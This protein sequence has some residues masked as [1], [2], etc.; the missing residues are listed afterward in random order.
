MTEEMYDRDELRSAQGALGTLLGALPGPFVLLGGWAV[1]H[2][3]QGSYRRD[4]GISYLG[5]RDLDVGYHVDPSWSD[6]ELR[7]SA[8]SRA[9]E[10]ARGI[11]YSPMGSFR[12][13][14]FVQKM[15]GW[16]LTEE[17]SK[18]V[19]IH[20]LFYL[21]LDFMVD[22]I[23]PRQANVLGPKAMDE[24]LLARV[25]EEG[26]GVWIQVGEAEVLAPPPHL[27]LAMKLK[28]IPSRQKE[29]KVIKDACDIYALLWH[30]PHGIDGVLRPVRAD[31]PEEC[32]FGLDA[33]TH[34]VARRASGHLGVDIESYLGVVRQLRP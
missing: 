24:P 21:Y 22:H 2:T 9:I 20:D 28:S 4:H 11:G 8:L 29:D 32:L 10:V 7:A 6:D 33:I 17:E 15:T 5:S 30:S 31:Y 27:L 1:Y 12:F 13:C 16:T 23:H 34:E 19:P 14:R 25:F 3:V 18:R 26:A